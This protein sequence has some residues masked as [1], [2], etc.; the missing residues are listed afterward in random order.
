MTRAWQAFPQTQ[1]LAYAAGA[2]Q[3][4]VG[5]QL[6]AVDLYFTEVYGMPNSKFAEGA[7]MRMMA[8]LYNGPSNSVLRRYYEGFKY[9]LAAQL[10][11]GRA[12]MRAFSTGFLKEASSRFEGL[13]QGVESFSVQIFRA[14]TLMYLTL[15][16]GKPQDEPRRLF[17]ELTRTQ[18]S[19]IPSYVHLFS[20]HYCSKDVEGANRWLFAG[21]RQN[22]IRLNPM[23]KGPISTLD[24][25][26]DGSACQPK[27]H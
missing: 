15:L 21:I 6:E 19:F 10:V 13:A 17:A 3:E 12:D 9:Y 23:L 18:P 14:E 2:A 24:K 7:N 22:P 5:N 26:W 16:E 27:Q 25:K 1:G 8:V 20:M 11:L 4:E